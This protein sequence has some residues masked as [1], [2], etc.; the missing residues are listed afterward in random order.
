MKNLPASKS[1]NVRFTSDKKDYWDE[2]PYKRQAKQAAA[3]LNYGED[4][5]SAVDR[6]KNDAEIARIMNTARNKKEDRDD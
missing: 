6:A 2:R 5:I 4:V 1:R 3:D